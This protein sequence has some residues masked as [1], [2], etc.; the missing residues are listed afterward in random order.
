MVKKYYITYVCQHVE[1]V[2]VEGD[3]IHEAIDNFKSDCFSS[4]EDWHLEGNRIIDKIETVT[5]LN[6]FGNEKIK[7]LKV[8]PEYND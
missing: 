4:I 5:G 1:T 3:N 2:C 7:E 6:E 8:K